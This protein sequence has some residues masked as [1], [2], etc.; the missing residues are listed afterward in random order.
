VQHVLHDTSAGAALPPLQV[1]QEQVLHF[2]PLDGDIVWPSFIHHIEPTR[3]GL[4]TPGEGLKVGGHHDG[5]V[6]SGDD[7]S[8]ELDPTRID[9]IRSYVRSWLPGVADVPQFGTTCLYTTTPDESFVVERHGPIVVGSPCS[10]HGFK[11][12]PLIGRRLADLATMQ[13]HVA[14]R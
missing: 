4:H 5:P 13:G 14:R 2:A 7:R 8:F 11:F 6:T 10:G 9:A 12:A 1:T 3:Y